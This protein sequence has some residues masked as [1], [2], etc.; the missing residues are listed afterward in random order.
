[1]AGTGLQ[2]SELVGSLGS[3]RGIRST[4]P[5][6]L[7]TSVLVTGDMGSLVGRVGSHFEFSS[8][9]TEY[10]DTRRT[11]ANVGTP[12][13]VPGRMSTTTWVKDSF[14]ISQIT[15]MNPRKTSRKDGSA[16]VALV[17]TPPFLMI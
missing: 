12:S 17:Q 16:S 8:S 4:D 3:H 5:G 15:S 2:S 13:S 1:M 6:P 14:A 7:G 10:K 11:I 9:V